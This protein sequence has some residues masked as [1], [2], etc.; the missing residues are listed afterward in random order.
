MNTRLKSLR[1]RLPRQSHQLSC[2]YN[3]IQNRHKQTYTL[4]DAFEIISLSR[5]AERNFSSQ[6]IPKELM[7]KLIRLTQHAPSSFNLQPYR[8]LVVNSLSGKDKLAG[9]MI[10]KNE[11]RVRTAPVTCI[12]AADKGIPVLLMIILQI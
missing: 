9:A 6:L 3:V 2:H 5:T 8:L 12:F 4:E 10:G 11:E 1:L 7:D